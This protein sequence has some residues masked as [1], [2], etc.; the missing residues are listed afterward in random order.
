M[1]KKKASG[2]WLGM[3]EG[4]NASHCGWGGR[5]KGHTARTA[6][7]AATEADGVSHGHALFQIVL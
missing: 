5:S 7:D 2:K 4:L 3:S 6:Q 1:R